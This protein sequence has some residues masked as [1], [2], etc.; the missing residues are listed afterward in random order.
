MGRNGE[1][2]NPEAVGGAASIFNHA[3]VN[4]ARENHFS[5]LE[6]NDRRLRHELL[7]L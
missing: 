2:R 7:H 5:T 3:H 4:G 6:S 1:H